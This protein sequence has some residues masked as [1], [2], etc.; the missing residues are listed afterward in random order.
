MSITLATGTRIAVGSTF[1]TPADFSSAS[2][3]TSCILSF[4]ADPSIAQG[5]IVHVTKSGWP[6][7]EGVVARVSAIS[8]SGPYLVTLEGVDTSNV[9]LYPAGEGAGT[10][11]K[12]TAFATIPLIAN[13]TLEGGEQQYQDTPLLANPVT[14]RLPSEKETITVR[15]PVYFEATPDAGIAAVKAAADAGVPC[16]FRA[17]H[18]TGDKI[19]IS[20]QW[21]LRRP[22][23]ME[24]GQPR[25]SEI[26]AVWSPVPE[27]IYAT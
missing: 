18:P 17:T 27:S 25:A 11:K 8:G 21:S 3:A 12:V 9:T 7:L 5:D 13:A 6:L 22:P 26:T 20:A 15:C 2:N 24:R 1:G 10:A 14:G 19:Y 23:S 16:A 4:A